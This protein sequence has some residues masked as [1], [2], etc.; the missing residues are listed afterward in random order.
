[1][2]NETAAQGFDPN[3]GAD[4][5][6]VRAAEK[7]LADAAELTHID[8]ATLSSDELL[9]YT[10]LLGNITRVV[11][12]QQVANVGDIARRSDVDAGFT[13][14]AARHGSRS[15][16]VLFE[17]VTG[18]KN[19]TAYRYARVAEDAAPRV[20][21][22]GLPLDPIFAKTAEHLHDGRIGLDVAEVVTSLLGPVRARVAPENLDW[23]EEKL[24]GN[25]TGAF[26]KAPV[27]AETLR[28]QARLFVSVMDPDGV[29]PSAEEL[30]EAR[31][32]VFRH[33]DDGSLKIAG[34]L[35][36]EQAVQITPC[37]TPTCRQELRRRS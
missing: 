17:K 11:E 18:V 23:A 12:G 37:S 13:G 25:A 10:G 28:R 33:L 4:A 21:D 20:S 8:P 2:R 3:E 22:T 19:S 29:A 9:T 36:P 32:L 24:L 27:S 31:K 30:H 26:G 35:S 15:P 5:V 34:T 16:A 1:M 6:A 7:L 14:L